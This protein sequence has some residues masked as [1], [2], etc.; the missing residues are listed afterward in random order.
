MNAV[1]VMIM[2]LKPIL[3]HT[4]ARH[5]CFPEVKR[6]L[7]ALTVMDPMTFFRL[8]IASQDLTVVMWWK[9]VR[10]VIPA[11]TGNLLAI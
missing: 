7:S 2:K 3:K 8:I 5:Q 11:P 10:N 9:P 4:T 6:L 1:H